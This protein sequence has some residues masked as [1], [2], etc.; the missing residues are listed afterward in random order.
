MTV[1]LSS[2]L[3]KGAALGARGFF[4]TGTDTGVGKTFVCCGLAAA[5]RSRR[6]RV[7][8]MKPVETGCEPSPDGGLRAADAELL[9]YYA[10]SSEPLDR[11]CPFRF[12]E[13][14]A[15]L[16]AARQSARDVDVP[17]LLRAFGE[18]A[19]ESDVVLVEGAGGLLVP[20]ASDITMADLASEMA[21]PLLVVVGS[22][23]G[24]INHARL[25]VECARARG[26]SVRGYVVN[27][28]DE[29][30]DAAAQT[31]VAVLDELLG[32]A[33]AVTPHVPGGAL[34]TATRREEL[35]RIFAAR[36]DLS[37]LLAAP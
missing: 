12:A 36:F 11:V 24:A 19:R 15:P 26:L 18:I 34:Q 14:L 9:R 30:P 33:L 2:E 25:T 27:F 31:N 21:L 6:W 4:V 5:L 28:L 16:V 7:G 3:L 32:P 29:A 13:P 20:V 17:H 22:R 10:D 23:L 35:A 8:V 1:L 37:A